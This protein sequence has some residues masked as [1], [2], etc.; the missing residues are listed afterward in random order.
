M[1]PPAGS[2][3]LRP[4]AGGVRV[5]DENRQ[6]GPIRH[7]MQRRVIG[8]AQILAEPDKGGFGHHAH[9]MPAPPG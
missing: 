3:A 4:G 8:K 6:D 1:Q 2:T 9:V 7:G 5:Q